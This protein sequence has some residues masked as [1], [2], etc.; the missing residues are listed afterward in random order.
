[1][2]VQ[3]TSSRSGGVPARASSLPSEVTKHAAC[4]AASSSSGLVFPSGSPT[5]D[6][7]VV[8]SANA[9]ELAAR[10]MPSPRETVPSQTMSASRTMRGMG[11]RY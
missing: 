11:R 5:R 6:A 4:A 3:W 7:I 10:T 1:M 8:G 2:I 9:P